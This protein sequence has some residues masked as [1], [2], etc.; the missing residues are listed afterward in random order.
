MKKLLLV[1]FITLVFAT[2]GLAAGSVVFVSAEKYPSSFVSEPNLVVLSYTCTSDAS[3]GTLPAKAITVA[4]VGFNYYSQGYY[5]LDARTINDATN[6]P[7]TGVA[8][9]LTDS[10]GT[11]FIG[12]T[13]GETLTP[14]TSASGIGYFSASRTPSQRAIVKALTIGAIGSTIGNSKVYTLRII[15]GK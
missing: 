1:V 12:S 2:V 5:L 15:L 14:S 11:Q 6:Y 9:T 13:V 7:T 3:A 8:V 10:D 4:D